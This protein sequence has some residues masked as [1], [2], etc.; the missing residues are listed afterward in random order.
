MAPR[1]RKRL[2]ERGRDAPTKGL[3]WLSVDAGRGLTH[4]LSHTLTLSHSLTHAI[5][6]STTHSVTHSLTRFIA[7]SLAEVILWR[8][9]KDV[10]VHQPSERDKI[11]CFSHL[12]LYWSWPESGDLWYK[13]GGSQKK[14]LS[15]SEDLQ[16]LNLAHPY[17]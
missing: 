8:G 13:S 10:Q 14:V 12:D 7:L 2:Q 1:T 17:P 5:T 6:D 11:A 16:V 4:S 9:L 3:L 15:H